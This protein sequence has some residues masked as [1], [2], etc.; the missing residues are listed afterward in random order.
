MRRNMP[1]GRNQSHPRKAYWEDCLDPNN[2]RP[3]DV[4]NSDSV[5]QSGNTGAKKRGR[6][7]VNLQNSKDDVNKNSR[8]PV[9]KTV[10]KGSK[11]SA[12]RSKCRKT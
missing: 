7:K 3:P 8:K 6:K 1:S 10:K 4:E 5:A 9:V 2:F 12:G 11:K